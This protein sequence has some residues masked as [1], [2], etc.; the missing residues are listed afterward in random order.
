MERERE[1]TSQQHWDGQL[2]VHRKAL[3]AVTLQT[4][5][6]A[7]HSD[8]VAVVHV[9]SRSVTCTHVRGRNVLC[10]SIGAG[11]VLPLSHTVCNCN[12]ANCFIFLVR[13]H[14]VRH[15]QVHP[16]TC[17]ARTKVCTLHALIL[18]TRYRIWHDSL[19]ASQTSTHTVR[20]ART[21]RSVFPIEHR[22]HTVPLSPLS[23]TLPLLS[24]S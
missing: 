2:R 11:C 4:N 9:A 10:A 19:D 16:P 24:C 14:G 7:L 3:K 15:F 12:C 21:S 23:H 5:P 8:D 13:S 1:L 18:G 22:Q 17:E 6:N 20:R